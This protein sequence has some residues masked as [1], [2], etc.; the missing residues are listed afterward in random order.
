[1]KAVREAFWESLRHFQ[2]HEFL[3]P[4]AMDCSLLSLLDQARERAGIPF[5]VTSSYRAGDPGSH[6]KGQ[7]VDLACVSSWER[8]ALVSSL[9]EVGFSRI[10]VYRRHVHVDVASDRPDGVLW[11]GRYHS[12]TTEPLLIGESDAPEA[13][14]S[15]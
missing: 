8:F 13:D 5:V 6:G 15:S 2:P 10:G 4:E 7:A 12:E 1:M 14:E 9:L 11:Y 3:D